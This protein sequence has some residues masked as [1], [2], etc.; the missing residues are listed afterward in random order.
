[1]VRDKEFWMKAIDLYDDYEPIYADEQIDGFGQV[2]TVDFDLAITDNLIKLA[3][4]IRAQYNYAP[5]WDDM[6]CGWYNFHICIEDVDGGRVEG[7]IYF[8]ANETVEDDYKEYFI[9]LTEEEMKWVRDAL[10]NALSYWGG[11]IVTLETHLDFARDIM[12]G[13]Y[14]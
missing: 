9:E 8:T 12:K 11:D 3:D 2:A 10:S 5:L 4:E 6:G 1:M 7:G 13:V 14:K